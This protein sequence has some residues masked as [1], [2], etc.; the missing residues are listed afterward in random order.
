MKTRIVILIALSMVITIVLRAQ[1][2]GESAP[3]F[4]LSD[5][6]GT[7]FTLSDQAGKVVMIYAFG[8]NCPYCLGNG[9]LVEQQLVQAYSANQNFVAVGVDIWN[10]SPSA[11]TSFKNSTGL[12][13]PLL[14]NGSGF[15]NDYNTVQDRLFVVDT[16]G[17]L[18]YRS[19]KAASNDIESVAAVLDEKLGLVTSLDQSLSESSGLLAFPN[20][21]RNMV[22]VRIGSDIP[23][24]NSSLKLINIDGRVIK[25]IPV[26][27]DPQGK[28][29]IE[30]NIE[31]ISTGLYFLTIEN[32][33][34]IYQ[35]KIFIE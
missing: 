32:N 3:D 25:E 23:P 4:M 22:T 34:E 29:E 33:G 13:M 5:L 11:V 30:I 2:I 7:S 14:L 19:N 9:P 31:G 15:G 1:E 18:A 26:Y 20:P 8:Y 21:A 6:D 35:Q 17:T 12:T 28:T 10:G 24:N 27:A 16:D